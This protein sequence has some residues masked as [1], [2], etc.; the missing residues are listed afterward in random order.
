MPRGDGTGPTGQG[1][2]T[3]R[4]MSGSDRGIGQGGGGRGM[5]GGNR[6]G[7]GPVGNCVC[8]SCG[9]KASHQR[10]VACYAIDC[11]KCG[12]KMVRE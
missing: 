3:G 4:G 2:K 12:S 10:G 1:P 7:A 5:G 6:P 11:P 8:P 9:A